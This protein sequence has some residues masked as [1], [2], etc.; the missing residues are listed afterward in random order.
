MLTAFSQYVLESI[1][2]V[3]SNH[4]SFYTRGEVQ[5]STLHNNATLN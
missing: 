1:L 3:K 4:N 5:G 2:Y